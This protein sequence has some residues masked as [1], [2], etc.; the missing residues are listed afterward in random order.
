MTVAALRWFKAALVVQALLVG[1]WL[2]IEVVD[3]FPW[4]DLASRSLDYGLNTE[5]AVTA[6]PLLGLMLLFALGVRPL[7]ILS[8]LG[9]LGYLVWEIWVWW[10]PFVI[11]ADPAWKAFYASNLART[12]KLIPA[13]GQHIPPDAQHLALQLLMLVTLL[14]TA[15]AT[16]HIRHL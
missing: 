11:G 5:I 3:I 16:G 2:A 6:L 9:Y 13:I 15:T 1:Y 8:V 4:N 10:K 12:L 14:V 7:A